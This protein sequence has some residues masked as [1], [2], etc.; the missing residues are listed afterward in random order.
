MGA[1]RPGAV[2][3]CCLTLVGGHFRLDALGGRAL[4]GSGA[5]AQK[6]QPLGSVCVCRDAP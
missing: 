1:S 6:K 3:H 2:A 4:L 5:A